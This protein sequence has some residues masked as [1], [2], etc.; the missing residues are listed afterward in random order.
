MTRFAA[1]V[2]QLDAEPVLQRAAQRRGV[3]ASAVEKPTR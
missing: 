2:E 3:S 1:V